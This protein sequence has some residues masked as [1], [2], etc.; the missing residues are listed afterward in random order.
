MMM[1]NPKHEKIV[2]E[3]IA[4]V[5]VSL[6]FFDEHKHD[7]LRELKGAFQ[8]ATSMLKYCKNTDIEATLVFIAINDVIQIDNSN[9]AH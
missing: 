1:A 9:F 3:G 8:N 6:D 2:N 5:D 7:G 4:E